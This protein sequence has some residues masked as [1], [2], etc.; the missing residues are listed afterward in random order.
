MIDRD[1]NVA[2]E[3]ILSRMFVVVIRKVLLAS[4]IE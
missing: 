1:E 2:Q 3:L 4:N